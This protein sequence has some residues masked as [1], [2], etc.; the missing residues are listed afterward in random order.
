MAVW[1][2]SRRLVL[3]LVV[4]C[5]PACGGRKAPNQ[6]RGDRTGVYHTVRSGETLYGVGLSYGLPYEEIA[7]VNGIADPSRIRV[8]QR[9]L[10]PGAKRAIQQAAPH[11]SRATSSAGRAERPGSTKSLSPTRKPPRQ[12]PPFQWPIAPAVVTSGFGPRGGGFHDGI[13]IA[14]E[15]GAP[16]RAAAPGEV[17]YSA[18]LPGYGKVIILRHSEGYATIYAHN[19]KHHVREKEQVRK[20][21]LIASVGKSGR[22]TG[23]NLHFEV[24]KDNVAH[25]PLQFLPANR[26]AEYGTDRRG[27]G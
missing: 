5:L 13:D 15:L 10:I 1:S 2:W 16:V 22:A 6:D 8:G 19:Q 17:A 27:G 23:T 7:R 20:G 24:R 21:Q 14:A 4:V 18:S 11:D 25:D 12:A 9:L 26:H 3:I